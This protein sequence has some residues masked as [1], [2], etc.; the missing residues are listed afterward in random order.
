MRNKF[1]IV[2]SC[3]CLLSVVLFCG[4][5]CSKY[6]GEED[7][8]VPV[9]FDTPI[10]IRVGEKYCIENEIFA[11]NDDIVWT[12]SDTNVVRVYGKN[13][14]GIAVGSVE[15]TAQL[16]SGQKYI[17]K[18]NVVKSE[19]KN[20]EITYNNVSSYKIINI[21]EG[22]EYKINFSGVYASAEKEFYSDNEHIVTVAADGTIK[23]V[24]V[25]STEVIIIALVSTV[26]VVDKIS[27]VVGDGSVSYIA[28]NKREIELDVGKKEIFEIEKIVDH[29]SEVSDYSGLQ[30]S[31]D[32][33]SVAK[34]SFDGDYRITAV[35]SGNT[36]IRVKYSGSTAEIQGFIY[37]RVNAYKSIE[38]IALEHLTPETNYATHEYMPLMDGNVN[39]LQGYGIFVQ[40]TKETEF[41]SDML[42][43]AASLG[44]KRIIFNLYRDVNTNPWA[45]ITGKDHRG[46]AN[47][48]GL[49]KGNLP[50]RSE[51]ALTVKVR[52]SDCLTDAGEYKLYLIAFYQAFVIES[53][54][55]SKEDFDP[56]SESINYAAQEYSY[57]YEG[58]V[59]YASGY[60][61]VVNSPQEIEFSSEILKN[62]AVEGF[63]RIILKIN[64]DTT[65]I[66]PFVYIS[67]K[68]RQG[69][70][71]TNEIWK[72][73]LPLAS[74]GGKTLEIKLSDCLSNSETYKLY[75]KVISDYFIIESLEFSKANESS[76]MPTEND[77]YGD[78]LPW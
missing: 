11:E 77:F 31:S 58:N 34:V 54:T 41:S 71:D 17:W 22:D 13:V 76:D 8:K 73:N 21:N 65:D 75:L 68:A 15:I 55:F 52:L 67:G 23:G 44:Y 69:S 70:A 14:I 40:T 63:N 5:S 61:F 57:L 6:S 62:A 56:V 36:I 74:V 35:S 51:N 49:F 28:L 4:C 66:N 46:G 24:S 78:D 7:V 42:K 39:F 64:R 12:V 1:I 10:E 32:N 60:G 37:V 43:G 50:F 3:I 16:R 59:G 20:T 27:V 45:E 47:A 53:I 25:G 2:L 18:V 19:A 72:G 48:K 26:R 33:E 30:F 9:V 38:D 29:G